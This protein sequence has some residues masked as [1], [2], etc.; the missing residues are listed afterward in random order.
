MLRYLARRLAFSV[1]LV[2]VVS[3]AALLLTLAAPGDITSEQVGSGATAR[4]IEAER[5][6]LGLDRPLF[7]QVRGVARP[8]RAAGFRDVAHVRAARRGPRG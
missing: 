7:E 6:R 1:L 2:A 4:S 5:A 8:R 3:S